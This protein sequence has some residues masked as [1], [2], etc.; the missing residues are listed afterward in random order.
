ME[1]GYG[2]PQAQLID[3]R[4]FKMLMKAYETAVETRKL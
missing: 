3:D 2:D 4:K 1:I